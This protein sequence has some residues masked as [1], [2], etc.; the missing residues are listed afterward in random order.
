MKQGCVVFKDVKKMLYESQSKCW[1]LCIQGPELILS[2]Y[3]PDEAQN[4]KEIFQSRST[5]HTLKTYQVFAN[6]NRGST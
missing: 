4:M 3:F 1:E 2:L 5:R 6:H